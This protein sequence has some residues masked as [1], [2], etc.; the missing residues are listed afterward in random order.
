[1]HESKQTD[2]RERE[3]RNMEEANQIKKALYLVYLLISSQT[4]IGGKKWIKQKTHTTMYLWYFQES[5]FL[6]NHQGIWY[7]K[8]LW[9][10]ICN[11]MQGAYFS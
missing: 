4:Y 1:M 11:T 2:R 8:M 7:L 9:F 10:C 5:Q 6:K 3:K